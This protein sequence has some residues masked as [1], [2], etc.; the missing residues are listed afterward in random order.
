MTVTS[1]D[2]VKI[3]VRAMC[4]SDRHRTI[5]AMASLAEQHNADITCPFNGKTLSVTRDD[6]YKFIDDIERKEL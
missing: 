6:A 4:G 1:I 3:E 5:L 2:I